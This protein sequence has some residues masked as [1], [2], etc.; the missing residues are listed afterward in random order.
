MPM[1]KILPLAGLALLGACTAGPDFTRPAPPP[2]QAGYASDGAGRAIE[3]EG[4]AQAWWQAFGSAELDALVARAIAGNHSLAASMA[5]LERAHEQIAAVRGRALPQ[6]SANARAE[7]QQLNLAAFGFDAFASSDGQTIRSPRF[8]LYTVGGGVSYDLDLFGRN[9]RAL[10]QAIAEAEATRRQTEAAH[11]L[12]AGRVVQQVLAIAALNDRIATERALLAED[13]RNLALTQKRERAGVGTL[14]EVLSAEAQL[15]DDRGS[16]PMMEQQLAEARNMLAILLGSSPAELRATDFT[17]ADFTLPGQV[18]VAVPS[19]LVR[20]RPDILETEARLHAAT[21][22]VGVATA[23]LYPNVTLGASLTQ[24]TSFP[25]DIFSGRF[26]GYNIFSGLTA[27]IFQGGTLKARQRGA[28]AN[29]R[30]AAATYRQTVLDAFG[31]V[32]NLLSALETDG[33]ALATQQESARI[34]QRS[35]HLSRRSFEV[36]N[37]GVLQVLE[38]SR[39]YQRAQLALVDARS[40]QYL[41]IAR[42]YVA[43]A[44]GWIQAAARAED[45][46]S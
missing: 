11:L 45:G 13:E 7:Y 36:G 21:A 46:T 16:L 25:E 33:R 22:A 27:P 17:L 40:R 2:P 9:R 34:A 23:E 37:S 31:Q 1:P 8:D 20:K 4:P 15:A 19:A 38:A 43:T 29:V 14:V 3:G 42:L 28:E 35:L 26:R 30:A 24:S 44:G 5:T 18:P 41:N 10:E 6:V 12:I 32:S 39:I